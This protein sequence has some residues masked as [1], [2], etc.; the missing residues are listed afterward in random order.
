MIDHNR[1][2][3]LH[4]AARAASAGVVELLAAELR[5]VTKGRGLQAED[6][7]GRRALDYARQNADEA[8]ARF[9]EAPAPVA[10]DEFDVV[11]MDDEPFEMGDAPPWPRATEAEF[12]PPEFYPPE[13]MDASDEE[14]AVPVPPPRYIEAEFDPPERMDASDDEEA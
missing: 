8:S 12:Y 4:S 6:R 14:E 7:W 1:M 11:H 9:L 3:P 2:T 5:G 13:R 10:E